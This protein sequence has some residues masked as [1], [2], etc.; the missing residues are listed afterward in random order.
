MLLYK[1]LLIS[2]ITLV[3]P[4]DI[5]KDR[6]LFIS[7][8]KIPLALSANFGELRSDH[9]HS[10]IDVKT[11]GVT[12]KEVIAAASGYV[13]RISISPGGFGKALYL[14]HPSGHSTVYGHLDRFSGEIDQYVQ[15]QQYL[16]KSFAVNLYPDKEKFNFNQGDII[17][18]SGNT[19]SSSGPH[20]HYEI[21]RT[22]GE[23]P[24]NPLL[25]EFGTGDNI[26]PVF[27]KLYIYPAGYNSFVNG[28][29]K[30]GKLTVAGAHGSYYIPG[31]KD[32]TISG[33]AGFGIKVY[34]LLND[35]YNRCAVYTIELRADS[36]SVYKYKMDEFSFGETKY[37]NSHIDYETLMRER[38]YIQ[39]TFTLPNDRFSAYEKIVN[40]G[41]VSFN[42]SLVH[43]IEIL[44]SDVHGNTS[45]LSFRV[46]GVPVQKQRW[47]KQA[48]EGQVLMPYSRSN[49]FRA[50]GIS[51]TIPAGSLYD[52]LRFEYKR[53]RG[54]PDMLSEVHYIHNKFTPLHRPFSL[55][56]KPS[57]IPAGKESKLLL[58]QMSDD[59]R[60]SAAGGTYSAG[61]VT[62]DV[63]SF[64]MYLV[65]IDTL[66]PVISPIGFTDG[67]DLSGKRELRIRIADDLSG[68]RSWEPSV[69]NTWA[70]FEYDQKNNV[71]IYNF[72]PQRITKGSVHSL[73]LKVIDNKDNSSLFRSSFRW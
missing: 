12:G 7:P 9:F 13:Y 47:I 15:E 24:L 64:G 34:D 33:S 62:G 65:G 72:D 42:D 70:L 23:V 49:R 56:I 5:L 71:L 53:D 11:Q 2:I 25:F 21:R 6:N 22:E 63:S 54:T 26:N 68:I 4:D 17:A 20:L 57:V 67:S 1:I 30:P 46:R 31:D 8:V 16:K 43:R 69:D 27:E 40:R 36:Q 45:S 35:S 39:R 29:N 38:I 73:E 44:V 48:D 41:L 55:S 59:F 19:G 37:I 61:Y 51:L 18:Y 32:L 10:G 66:A 50:E 52:T 28:E 14:R 3:F 58:L 60:K